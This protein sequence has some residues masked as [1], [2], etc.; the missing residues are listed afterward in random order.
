MERKQNEVQDFTSVETVISPT[1]LLAHLQG[2]RNLTR[3]LIEAFPEDQLFTYSIGGMRPF[4]EMV[5]ELLRMGAPGIKGFATDEWEEFERDISHKNSKTELLRLW[6]EASKEIDHYWAQIPAGRFQEV[7]LAFRQYEDEGT[8]I[9]LYFIDNEI[10]H[11]AQ[12]YVYLR[13]LGIA[14]PLFWER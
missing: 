3:R 14:P 2:H 10:H 4:A 5:V 11:R 8:A 7:M 9:I 6:D 1:A 13:S 12:G